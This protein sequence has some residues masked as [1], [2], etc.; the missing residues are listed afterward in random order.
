M[1]YILNSSYSPNTAVSNR[2]LA[3]IKGLSELNV[4]TTVM[5]FFPNENRSMIQQ[6]YPHVTFQYM[7]AKDRPCGR[8]FRGIRYVKYIFQ[9]FRQLKKGDNVYL[10]NMEDVMAILLWKKG[11]KIYAERGE[12]PQIY[13]LGS[14]IYRPSLKRYFKQISRI[15]G[16]FVISQAL[17]RYYVENGMPEE[18]VHVINIIVDPSRFDNITEDGHHEDYIAYCGT[19][20]NNKDGV[21]ELIKAFAITCK[22]HTNVKLYIIG[23]TPSKN[24]ESKNLQLIDQLGIKDKIVFTGIV[25]AKEMPALLTKAKVLAL[26]RPDNIQAKYGFPTKLGEYLLTKKPVVITRVGDI[27]LFLRDNYNAFI[28]R[29]EDSTDFAKKLNYVLD[30]YQ[31]ALE[32]GT[33][34]FDLAL[35][36]FNYLTETRKMVGHIANILKQIDNNDKNQ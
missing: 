33:R 18:K 1:F 21:D 16:L 35:Q 11:I 36:E 2:M 28:A 24:D 3:Y 9:V 30:N 25:K 31:E 32:V 17:K 14:P 12:H 26:D 5:F 6:K 4:D 19:A 23:K 15:D 8:A 10:Y 34:G 22:T 27:P 29:P 13:P 7:W 20:S